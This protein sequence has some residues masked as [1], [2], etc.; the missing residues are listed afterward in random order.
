MHPYQAHQH[1]LRRISIPLRYPTLPL[2]VEPLPNRVAQYIL[3]AQAAGVSLAFAPRVRYGL[4][5]VRVL[6]KKYGRRKSPLSLLLSLIEHHR[7]RKYPPWTRTIPL[8]YLVLR[9]SPP[10]LRGREGYGV[11]QVLLER[12][13]QAGV[14]A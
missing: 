3:F 13:R 2:A 1:P 10:F 9:K 11:W 8:M 12:K 7:R 5:F 6:L 4:L 14:R